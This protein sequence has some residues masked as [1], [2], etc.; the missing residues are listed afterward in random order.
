M[1]NQLL[2][3][4]GTRRVGEKWP[5]NFVNRQP[6]LTTRFNRKYDYQRAKNED[7]TVIGDWFRLVR[8]TKDKYGILDDD[9][10]N[11]DET[12][13]MMGVIST[14]LVV[15]ASDIRNRPKSIQPGNREWVTVIQAV[16]ALGWTIPPFIILAA[17]YHLAN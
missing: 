5:R 15:T 10:Y 13:F 16:N 3:A 6:E 2:A 8:N 17:Q 14:E 7:P 11:F 4:R 9:I 1:A 12:G